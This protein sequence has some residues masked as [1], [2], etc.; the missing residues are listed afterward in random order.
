[1]DDTLN[2]GALLVV[3]F[4]HPRIHSPTG[5]LNDHGTGC[6]LASAVASGLAR[7]LCPHPAVLGVP[8]PA[9]RLDQGAGGSEVATLLAS[10]VGEGIQFVSRAM[11]AAVEV[12]IG[13]GHGPLL[14]HFGA[15]A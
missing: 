1:V 13:Q 2:G 14:H 7:G 6:S 10:A 9:A 8:A 5:K 4:V 3:T 11:S 12:N 15:F